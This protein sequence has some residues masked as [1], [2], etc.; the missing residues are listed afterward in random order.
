MSFGSKLDPVLLIVQRDS[1]F[2]QPPA[3]HPHKTL[4]KGRKDQLYIFFYKSMSNTVLYISD[5]TQKS[6]LFLFAY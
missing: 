2:P 3:K 6:T 1:I 4:C 5:I